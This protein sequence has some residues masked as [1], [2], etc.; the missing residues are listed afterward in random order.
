MVFVFFQMAY[1]LRDTLYLQHRSSCHFFLGSPA[2]ISHH[3]SASVHV[4]QIAAQLLLS[5]PSSR[6]INTRG[7]NFCV[8]HRIYHPFCTTISRCVFIL[9]VY[10]VMHNMGCNYTI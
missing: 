7:R 8:K 5:K 10:S 4:T 9:V 1:E 3:L 6:S 2:R